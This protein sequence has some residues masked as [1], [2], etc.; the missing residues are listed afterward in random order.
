MMRW[1]I[2]T[3]GSAASRPLGEEAHRG[4]ELGESYAAYLV[5]GGALLGG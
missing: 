2:S 4:S 5:L 3:G 1:S